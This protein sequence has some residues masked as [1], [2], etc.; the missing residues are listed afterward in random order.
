[1]FIYHKQFIILSSFTAVSLSTVIASSV[2]TKCEAF[3]NQS[4]FCMVFSPRKSGFLRRFA[5]R[6]DGKLMSIVL[7][8]LILRLSVLIFYP[9]QNLPDSDV[10]WRAGQDLFNHGTM[11]LP[12][13]MPLYPIINYLAVSK[14]LLK[15]IDIGFSVA[16]IVLIYHLSFSI[17]KH[18]RAALLAAAIAAC[19]PHFIFYSVNRLTESS[20]VF[21]LLS[22][23]L[24]LHK[25][26]FGWGSFWMV[27]SILERP[28]LDLIA[29]LL[30]LVY[31][32]LIHR[33]EWKKCF[34]NL[35]G[36]GCVYV[37]LMAPW[38]AY[39]YKEYGQFVRLNLGAG[40]VLYSGNNPLNQTGGGVY[41]GYKDREKKLIQNDMDLSKF[42][43]LMSQDIVAWDQAMQAEAIDYIKANPKRFMELAVLKFQ[44]F[45]RL[46]PYSP[47][48]QSSLIKW[49][50]L[51]SYG[52]VLVGALG[53]IVLGLFFKRELQRR[54]WRELMPYYLFIGYLTLVH[55]VTIGSI[56]YRFPL[57]PLLIIFSSY[58]YIRCYLLWL[59]INCKKYVVTDTPTHA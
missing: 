31:G 2:A 53:F 17:F 13:S 29:P 18:K 40:I 44:R 41:N 16:S 6:N 12:W 55:M 47:D 43:S 3:L 15:L 24:A 38:W 25:G 46:W 32:R 20:Y 49:V 9:D 48:Y 4:I 54:F 22:A 7:L 1:M 57:E 27:L 21:L 45:W 56:R 26:C 33:L 52:P 28:S 8:G 50:S 11:N 10:Y 35:M 42:E 23:F 5:P 30:V 39:N 14:T 19:Y 51:L 37:L 34:K 36:Y 59:A 58:F